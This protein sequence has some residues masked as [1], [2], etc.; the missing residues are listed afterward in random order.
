MV[1]FCYT[2]R[3]SPTSPNPATRWNPCG[4]KQLP[5][6][7]LTVMLV[8]FTG[9]S[10]MISIISSETS[11]HQ[12]VIFL[13]AW[14]FD[15]LP[16]YLTKLRPAVRRLHLTQSRPNSPLTQK[17]R[18][19]NLQCNASHII[20]EYIWILHT[21]KMKP[22]F[23]Q[24]GWEPCARIHSGDL[25]GRVAGSRFGRSI[26][27]LSRIAHQHLHNSFEFCISL[28]SFDIIPENFFYFVERPCVD[29]LFGKKNLWKCKMCPSDCGWTKEFERCS[30]TANPGGQTS[31]V[32]GCRG[33]DTT[34]HPSAG[35]QTQLMSSKEIPGNS[36][37]RFL[38][39]I[40]SIQ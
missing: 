40:E 5:G 26:L 9:T 37:E 4:P 25:H 31:P 8:S 2:R 6:C 17:D 15:Y 23:S 36:P 33:P 16:S 14:Q 19:R 35:I 21:Q 11:D 27:E 28:I 20:Y 22:P 10:R 30:W 12:P 34:R 32:W 18:K 39:S 1:R 3:S 29:H 13:N 24:N 38:E 7:I